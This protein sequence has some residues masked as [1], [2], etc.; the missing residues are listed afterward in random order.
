MRTWMS[1]HKMLIHLKCMNSDHIILQT[2][3]KNIFSSIPLGDVIMTL[4][5]NKKVFLPPSFLTNSLPWGFCHKQI[6]CQGNLIYEGSISPLGL[7]FK[8]WTLSPQSS[9]GNTKYFPLLT[10]FPFTW[11]TCRLLLQESIPEPASPL[12]WPVCWSRAGVERC[13]HIWPGVKR[14]QSRP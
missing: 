2:T 14:H 8:L 6:L 5:L 13:Q 11:F 12:P 7:S 9:S 4:K 10:W 3:N 1:W